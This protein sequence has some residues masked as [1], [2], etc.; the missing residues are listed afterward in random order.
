[1]GL[2][3]HQLTLGLLYDGVVAKGQF[4]GAQAR[5]GGVEL[6]INTLKLE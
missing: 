4:N 5:A 1:L 2:R 3:L 6:K